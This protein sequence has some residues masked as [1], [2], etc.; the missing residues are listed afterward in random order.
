MSNG[1]KWRVL[2][3]IR[4][5]DVAGAEKYGIELARSLPRDRFDIQ[6]CAFFE[7]HT[8]NEIY[9]RN[10]LNAEKI[11]V[12][13]FAD[14]NTSR[15]IQ[16]YISGY[17]KLSKF[18]QKNHVDLI[19]SHFSMGTVMGILLKD[20]GFAQYLVRTAHGLSQYEWSPRWYSKP[21]RWLL[22]QLVYPAKLDGETGVS[23]TVASELQEPHRLSRCVRRPRMIHNGISAEFIQAARA[24]PKNREDSEYLHIGSIGRLTEQKGFIYLIQAMPS[25]LS[26]FPKLK[27]EI[28]GEGELKDTLLAEIETLGLQDSV[29]ILGKQSDVI[30]FLK[31]LDLFVL[32]SLWEGLPTVVL[33]SM[34]CG[35]PVLAT[36]IPGT[37]E[38]INHEVNGWLV[39]PANPTALA[40]GIKQ[41][42]DSPETL[43]R[44]S[45]L[46][47]DQVEVF[48]FG[49]IAAEFSQFYQS[50]LSGGT[51]TL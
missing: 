36:D 27:L 48:S 2:Q 19:H 45:L 10:L 11:D 24:V 9:W 13:S 37:R 29:K 40:A 51:G 35:T 7:T 5:L 15:R 43:A 47:Q 22:F 46:A 14:I 50:I 4:S 44:V 49:R 30:P 23:E 6:I 26:S 8:E 3:M 12:V 16:N 39:E 42:L 31:R 33:E 32:P 28:L 20:A 38:L 41:L 17:K 21:W 25:L 34:A 18:V 1:S